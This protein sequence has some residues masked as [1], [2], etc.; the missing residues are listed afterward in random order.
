MAIISFSLQKGGV[1]KTSMAINFSSFLAM[2]GLKT[3]VI[4]FD[5]QANVT[6]V[7]LNE[8]PQSAVHNIILDKKP[9]SDIIVESNVAG[10]DIL[11][12]DIQFASA[13]WAL[14]SAMDNQYVLKDIIVRNGLDTQYDQIV[15]DAPPNLSITMLNVLCATQFVIIPLSCARFSLKGLRDFMN[16]LI[17]IR[18]RPNPDIKVLGAFLNFFDKRKSLHQAIEADIQSLF[19]E[20][21]FDSR[22]RQSVK[23]DEA[24]EKQLPIFL[25]AKNSSA[26]EDVGQFCEEAVARLDNLFLPDILADYASRIKTSRQEATT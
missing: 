23:I 15:I 21:L 22:I 13:E 19:G 7:L 1:G 3:L 6:E 20:G 10:L 18:K 16:T 25:Y 9:A 12:S 14:M 24:S 5:P 17:Q 11:P 26:A 2:R 8:P 4:D